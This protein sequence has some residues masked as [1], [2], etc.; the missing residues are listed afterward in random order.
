MTVNAAWHGR[1]RMPKNPSLDQRIAWH[2][3]HQAHCACRAIPS[4]LLSLIRRVPAA[5]RASKPGA[6]AVARRS[7]AGKQARRRR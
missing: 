5:R 7:P 6:G 3:A 4:A 2:T 1:H